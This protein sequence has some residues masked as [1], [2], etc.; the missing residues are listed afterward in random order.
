MVSKRTC[1]TLSVALLVVGLVAYPGRSAVAPSLAPALPVK[2]LG[3]VTA[4]ELVAGKEPGA[5]TLAGP[6]AVQQI[7]VTGRHAGGDRS[8]LTRAVTY[9][10]SPPGIVAVD[11]AGLATPLK[12]GR[13]TVTART[14]AGLSASVS[15][16]VSRLAEDVPINFANEVV[17]IFTRFGCNAGACHGRAS[18]Q[19][20]FKLSLLGFEAVEDYEYLV[21]EA[22]GRRLLPSAAEQSLLVRKATGQVAHGGGKKIEP[23]SPYH[24]LLV[25]WIMQGAP[26]GRP[27]DPVVERIELLPKERIVQ[28]GG[29]Q[30]LVVL[31]H[32]SDGT[33]RDVTRMTQFESNQPE[34]AAV[35]DTGLVSVKQVPGRASVMARFQSHV[36]VFRAAVPLGAPLPQLPRPRSVVDELVFKQWKEL[37]LPPS[38]LADDST[39]LRR[40]T[41]DLAGRLPTVQETEAFLADRSAD[42][43]DKLID[44]LLASDGHA[45]YFANKWSAVLRNR[46]A[47]ATDDTA[48]TFAFHAWLRESVAKNK[49]YDRFVREVLTATGEEAKVPPV[50]W[51]RELKEPAG[52]VEDAAQL[53][54]GQR[55]GCAKCHHH[56]FEKWSQEDYWGM[57][58]FF[59]RVKVTAPAPPKKKTKR[60][61]AVPRKPASVAH[62]PGEAKAVNPRTGKVV[63]PTGLGDRPLI[64]TRD[65]DPR[66]KLVDWMVRRD[67][68][69]FARALVNRYWKHFLG[70]GLVDPED[71]LRATNPSSNDELLDALAK[72]FVES[73]YDVKKLVR[74]ICTSH[75]YRLSAVPN[76]YNADDR[77]SFSRFLPRRLT[78]EVLLDSIDDLAGSRTV[79]KGA[80]AGTRAVQLPDNLFDSYFLSVFGRPDAASACECERSQEASLAQC[81]HMLNSQEI[82]NKASGPRA[83]ALARDKRPHEQRIRELYHIALSRDPTPEESEA[84]VE[85]VRKK[86]DVQAAYEDVVWALINTKEFQFNH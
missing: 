29:R 8:D 2:N 30:Q 16:T 78:A 19:N 26:Y 49:P 28:R 47:G 48:P 63:R 83:R 4:L 82:L 42:R 59:S 15:V 85:H 86:G 71:D 3:P 64:L 57:V 73:G 46:R 34:M 25:R 39:F 50:V 37:G 27:S 45:D 67:N 38:A 40:A 21:K 14:P 24:R 58:A 23:G 10:T 76:R 61:A 44:R 79:F 80:K 77:Q 5:F 65:N 18:G 1:A 31:A 43:H 55:I 54:L 13:A 17:P 22:R 53:F 60:A 32:L 33:A 6:D 74:L 12:D 84:L 52:M 51:F 7:L 9:E 62:E 68:P 72:S 11:A 69:F 56:P 81:L 20:G 70:R 36:A 41:I 35:S 66:E 75:A